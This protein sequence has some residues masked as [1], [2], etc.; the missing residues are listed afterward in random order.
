[1]IAKL[2]RSPALDPMPNW[3]V[4]LQC[5]CFSILFA[6]WILPETILIRHI[7]LVL[8]GLLSLYAI[9]RNR[10]LLFTRAALP[11]YLILALFAWVFFHLFFLSRDPDLQWLEFTTIWKRT[12]IGFIFAIGMGLSVAAQSIYRPQQVKLTWWIFYLGLALPTLIYW[13]KFFTTSLNNQGSNASPDFLLLYYAS[14]KYY[15]HKSSYVFFCLPLL[16]VSLGRIFQMIKSTAIRRGELVIYL[17][18]ICAALLNFILEKDRNG[19]I[20][21]LLFLLIFF[22]LLA[23]DYVFASSLKSKVIGLVVFLIPVAI[24]FH[25]LKSNEYWSNLLSDAH[26]AIQIDRYDHWQ[27]TPTKGLPINDQGKMLTGSNYERFAWMHV[28]LRLVSENPLGYGLVERS[29]GYLS[30]KSWPD[31]T[32]TQS[33]SG[34]LD[35]TLG[36]GIPATFLLLAAGVLT[37]AH[38]KQEN[39]PWRAFGLWGIAVLLL[40]PCTTEVSQRVYIDA[41]IFMIA[42]SAAMNIGMTANKKS[43]T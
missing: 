2:P 39:L 33:H 3:L 18:G 30:Q 23:K 31:S 8:G 36:L 28:A 9:F 7:C 38:A 32:L 19:E 22:A 10:S 25:Q 37:W 42:F 12:A 26:I 21:S 11:I 17:I 29:F 40:L 15:I 5:I 6:I 4:N 41:L 1:M 27:D 20:Y 35:F 13:L 24:G 34:W 16:A 43:E 14:S